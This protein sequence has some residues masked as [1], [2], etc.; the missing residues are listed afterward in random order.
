MRA[1]LLTRHALSGAAIGLAIGLGAAT[2][3]WRLGR[4]DLRKEAPIVVGAAGAVAGLVVARRKRWSDVDV[5]LFLDERLASDEAITTAIDLNSK[6]GVG[7]QALDDDATDPA[8]AVV[9]SAAEDALSKN[10]DG[11]TRPAVFKPVHALLPL[12]AAGL[13]F[14]LRAPMPLHPILAQ[15]P[16]TSTIQVADIEGLTH[17]AELTKVDAR[18]EA[19]RERLDKIAKDA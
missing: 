9:L 13:V 15:A 4:A 10:T 3:A 5:A 8:R 7:V 18:D 2:L 19:Q 16:G 14:V 1:R 6:R 12:A 11:K 17:V